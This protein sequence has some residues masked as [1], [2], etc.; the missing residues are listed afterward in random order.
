MCVCVCVSV[1]LYVCVSVCLCV[2]VCVCV[3]V[4]LYVSV[5]LCAVP[6]HPAVLM[7]ICYYVLAREANAKLVYVSCLYMLLRSEWDYKCPHHYLKGI[8]SPPVDTSLSSGRIFSHQLEVPVWCT[9]VGL[10]MR[11]ALLLYVTTP[12]AINKYLFI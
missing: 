7:E 5:G 8:T 1:C 3:S 4:Y 10:T 11:T 12:S 9:A 2:S 6:V